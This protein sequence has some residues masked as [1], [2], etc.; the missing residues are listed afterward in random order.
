MAYYKSY[1]KVNIIV[2]LLWGINTKFKI[3]LVAYTYFPTMHY[4]NGGFKTLSKKS[5]LCLFVIE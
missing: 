2:R 3:P 5:I 1:R 4:K